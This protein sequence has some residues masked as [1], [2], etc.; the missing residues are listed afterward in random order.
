MSVGWLI[1]CFMTMF[2]GLSMAEIVSAIPTSGGPYFWAAMLAPSHLAPFFS[3]LVGWLN[4]VGQFAV[5]TGI[6]FGLAG[7]IATTVTV[8]NKNYVPTPGHIIG[9]YAAV[10]I[11]HITVNWF[12]VKF[13]RYLNN[14]SILL[15]SLGVG[16]LAI[17]VVAKAPTHRSAAE[18]F[19]FFNDSTGVDGAP[20]WS[21]R[22]SPAYVA[23]C[24]ILLA[25]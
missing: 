11:S 2:V 5:T 16:A 17:A 24:G 13:L 20:G 3:W 21:E 19:S 12:G 9:I 8:K 6:S 4:F 10:L 18:V 7:L 25:Q 22:A 15:H 1:V 23:I 14:T